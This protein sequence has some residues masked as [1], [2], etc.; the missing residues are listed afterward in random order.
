MININLL[1]SGILNVGKNNI[2]P[3]KIIVNKTKDKKISYFRLAD[4][5][6]EAHNTFLKCKI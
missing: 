4:G 1:C 2:K 6:K 5:F 3:V